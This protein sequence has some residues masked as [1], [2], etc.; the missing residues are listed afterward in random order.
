[1]RIGERL[2]TELIINESSN[3]QYEILKLLI[4]TK[5]RMM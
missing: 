4:K 5:E 2:P 1:M 3:D